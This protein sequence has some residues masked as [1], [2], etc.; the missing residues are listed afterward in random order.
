[1]TPA[2]ATKR[3]W[4]VIKHSPAIADVL[5]GNG[6]IVARCGKNQAEQDAAL[7]VAA[8]NSHDALLAQNRAMREVLTTYLHDSRLQTFSDRKRFRSEAESALSPAS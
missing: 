1:M 4:K 3:P 6:L 8:V 5:D 2:Q 7:I